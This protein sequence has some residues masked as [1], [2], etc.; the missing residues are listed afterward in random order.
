L[1]DLMSRYLRH[2]LASS[3]LRTES[4][5]LRHG[6]SYEASTGRCAGYD[7]MILTTSTI[8]DINVSRYRPFPRQRSLFMGM[9]KI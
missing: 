5:V 9:I 2:Q 1:N 3:G 4:R 8:L 6:T 7:P